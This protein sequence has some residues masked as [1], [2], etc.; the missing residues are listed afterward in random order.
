MAEP[1]R[2]TGM[3]I[4]KKLLDLQKQNIVI[5][6]NGLNPHFR[7][8]YATLND[9]LEKIKPAL[10]ALGV[11]LLQIPSADGLTTFLMDTEDDSKV[12]CFMP[13]VQKETAQQLGSN[14][15]YNRRYS[16]I[17][18]LG[19]EDDDTD[20]EMP[21]GAAKPRPKPSV[22]PQVPPTTVNH[23]VPL[24]SGL[25]EMPPPPPDSYYGSKK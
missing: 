21:Q 5:P 24:N 9:V 3:S 20:G 25:G 2:R 6:K 13:Y 19:L 15:T 16:L 12:E 7:S 10:N 8:R 14:N 1:V 23:G 4:Y 18:L 11:V 17:T 22:K